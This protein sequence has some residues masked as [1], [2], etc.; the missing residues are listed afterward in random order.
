MNNRSDLDRKAADTLYR[1]H[2][3]AVVYAA[4][5]VVNPGLKLRP[6]W[7]IDCVCH[8]LQ[9]MVTGQTA[10]RLVLNQPP[11]SLKSFIVSVCLPAWLL[12]RNPSS[13][14]ICASYSVDLANKFSRD[15]RSLID[16]PFYKRIF[17]RTRLNPKKATEG[18]FETTRRGYRFTTSVGGTLTGRGGD[19]LIIDDPIK[20]NDGNS[21]VALEGAI[22]WFRNTALS[23]L[24]NPG[25]SLIIVTMQ[26]LHVNDLSGILI[27][28]GWP[29]LVLPAIA[30]EPI[31]HVVADRE[32]HHRPV[33]QLLQPDRDSMEALE[34]I[35]R[36]VGSRVFAAQYQQDPTPPD[37]NLIKAAW[38]KRY[39]VALD[40]TSYRNVVLSCDPA[41]KAGVLNDY[42]AITIAGVSNKEL[43]LL[44]VARGH[45]SVLQ[46]RDQISALAEH[47][48]PDLALIE[49]TSSGMGLIQLLREQTS[50]SIV[51]RHPKDDKETRMCRHQGRFEAGRVLLPVEAPWL[52]EF[53]S[54]LLSFPSGRYDDQVDAFMLFLDWFSDNEPNMNMT[55]ATPI[56][57]TRADMG[58]PPFIKDWSCRY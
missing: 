37:G 43:H 11:R 33:G 18:E 35:R 9:M 27:E 48:K 28:S 36:E 26:R 24:D 39:Q 19:V 34:E 14:I 38:L 23:R 8:H 7:H 51:G 45:W 12:G 54:E 22:D 40:R 25:E 46:M 31:D 55:W 42:T 13:R 29:K 10:K 5:A 58:L 57:I 56:V 47:W 32:V 2:F 4:F 49:D 30:T 3:G 50:L 6:N 16:S 53:E 1:N 20:G 44:H 52:A 17:P 21:V 41:G 15:C